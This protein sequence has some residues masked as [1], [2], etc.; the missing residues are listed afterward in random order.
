MPLSARTVFTLLLLAFASCQYYDG[1]PP[2]GRIYVPENAEF[3]GGELQVR[4]L[5]I[6]ERNKDRMDYPEYAHNV[7][8]YTIMRNTTNRMRYVHLSNWSEPK[9][10]DLEAAL[11]GQ[12]HN[13]K[14]EDRATIDREEYLASA[15]SLEFELGAMNDEWPSG[16]F[17][18][19]RDGRLASRCSGAY[20]PAG[21]QTLMQIGAG[22]WLWP[23]KDSEVIIFCTIP[24]VAIPVRLRY[25]GQWDVAF[26]PGVFY[27]SRISEELQGLEFSRPMRAELPRHSEVQ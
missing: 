27:D 23:M 13:L 21:A 18:Y 6:E 3:T 1:A 12:L 19:I 5:G 20:S 9:L 11:A 26:K 7:L 14:K 2:T 22:I 10:K 16:M 24:D 25:R 4:V 8:I 17:S 15:G